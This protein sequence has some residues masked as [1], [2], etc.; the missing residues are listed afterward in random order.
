[1]M[2]N[3]V[4]PSLM[5]LTWLQQC[6]LGCLFGLWTLANL[7]PLASNTVLTAA[8]E[9]VFHTAGI[10]EGKLALKQVQFPIRVLPWQ[11]QGLQQLPYFQ[12]YSPGAY[13]FGGLVNTVISNPYLAYKF[14]IWI[15]L[16]IAASYMYLLSL[17][18]T[19]SR[20]IA[21]LTG[22]VYIS[23]PYFLININTHAAYTEVLAQGLIP[24]TLYY[25]LKTYIEQY[26]IKF[27]SITAVLWCTLL[28]M[29]LITFLYTTLFTGILFLLSTLF[30]LSSWKKLIFLGLAFGVGCLLSSW[31]LMPLIF[32]A[33]YLI[34]H[35]YV[36]NPIGSNWLTPIASLLSISAIS[37]IP[38]LREA[39]NP[40]N[41]SVPV[42]LYPALGWPILIGVGVICYLFSQKQIMRTSKYNILI[43]PL[44]LLFFIALFV[45]WS[46]VNFW[47]YLPSF[48][49]ITQYTYRILTQT[50]WIGSL[51]FGYALFQLFHYQMDMRHIA[52]GL[53]L[54][55]LA[56]SSWLPTNQGTLVTPKMIRTA[57][58][59]GFAQGTYLV[60]QNHIS[61][62]I[63]LGDSE[64]PIN[65]SIPTLED[66][67]LD[68]K[69]ILR[70]PAEII[71]KNPNVILQLKGNLNK[72]NS[73]HDRIT[74][75]LKINNQQTSETFIPGDIEWNIPL[76]QFNKVDKTYLT[77]QFSPNS[78]ISETNEITLQVKSLHLSNVSPNLKI[79]P[80][81]ELID[82][83]KQVTGGKT[84]C[85]V[86]MDSDKQW[87][88]LPVP[89]YR[90]M[91]D[92]KVNDQSVTYYPIIYR[93][94]VLAGVQLGPGDYHIQVKFIGL[95]WA[96]WLSGITWFLLIFSL[97]YWILSNNRWKFKEKYNIEN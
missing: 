8:G 93:D 19:Q 87:L 57:P 30:G 97:F 36:G 16:V 78:F 35:R 75:T 76:N 48:L 20:P 43:I 72:K 5:P 51:L 91:L 79:V 17:K 71:K 50:M 56:S 25:S 95:R 61:N 21:I 42:P 94:L 63:F 83:C 89:Y 40:G 38:I 2:L 53:L 26:S 96:N 82:K 3:K 69:K 41:N 13:I 37:P 28:M 24:I 62:K 90:N 54:L 39:L 31:H 68:F 4:K 33:K 86:K 46:P 27:F 88:Q 15:I 59:V 73:S 84:I 9:F 11:Q 45:A 47:Q 12:F 6:F 80:Y 49:I 10:V 85:Q 60:D 67:F 52:V 32:E 7:A 14:S 1:M 77:L 74:L 64:L 70:I 29:H 18:F 66:H 92:I 65:D 55:G 81:T 34:I 44:I 58:T 23:S 22:I